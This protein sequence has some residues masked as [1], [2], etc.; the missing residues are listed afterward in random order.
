LGA[1]YRFRFLHEYTNLAYI[2][3]EIGLENS[4]QPVEALSHIDRL[5]VQIDLGQ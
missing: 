1:T 3:M 5:C 2:E 4:K